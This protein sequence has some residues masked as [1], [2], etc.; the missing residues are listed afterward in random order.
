M[1]LT[2][3]SEV[4]ESPPAVT[5]TGAALGGPHAWPAPDS[6]PVL[7]VDDDPGAAVT[8]RATLAAGGY[9]VAVEAAGDA[10]LRL[11]RESLIRLVVAELY[12]PCSEGPCVVAALKQDRMRLPRLRVLVYTRHAAPADLGWA[13]DAGADAIVPKAARAGVLLRE[14]GRLL[15]GVPAA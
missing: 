6:P 11:V 5:P 10:V 12:V 2:D 13:L 14:V 9:A 4:P 8:T 15:D 7:V 1:A 3:V